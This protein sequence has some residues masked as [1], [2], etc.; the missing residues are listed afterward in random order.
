MRK[1][2]KERRNAID[3]LKINHKYRQFYVCTNVHRLN[4]KPMVSWIFRLIFRLIF[5]HLD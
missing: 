2:G 4:Q 3:R 5:D 1:G